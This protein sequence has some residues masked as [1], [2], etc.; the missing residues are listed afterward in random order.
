MTDFA[1]DAAATVAIF[2]FFASAWFGWAQERPPARWRPVLI[3]GVI[4][5]LA[6]ALAGGFW[7]WRGWSSG[8]AFNADTSR[9]FGLVVGLELLLA[10]VGVAV[11]AIRRHKEL[12]SAWVALIVGLHL[13]PVA[14]LLEFP[15]LHAVAAAIVVVSIAAIPVARSRS[16][17]VSAVTG[18]GAGSV[19][20]VAALAFIFQST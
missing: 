5:S 8:T 3:A 20:L 13:F 16:V 4:A 1:R 11:L 2:G 10:A 17:A 7:T 19:L 14:A 6:T 12:S 15:L 18:L 9:L